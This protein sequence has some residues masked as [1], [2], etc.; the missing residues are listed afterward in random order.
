VLGMRVDH[1]ATTGL[2]PIGSHRLLTLS[3]LEDLPQLLWAALS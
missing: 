1:S 3:Q 2:Q